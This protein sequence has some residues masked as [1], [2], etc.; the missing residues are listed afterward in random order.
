MPGKRQG[1]QRHDSESPAHKVRF[2]PTQTSDDRPPGN[3]L[4]AR[5]MYLGSSEYRIH[6]TNNPATIGKQVSSGRSQRPVPPGDI[7][8]SLKLAINII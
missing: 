2:I 5:A 1:C 8:T 4:G 6:G 7:F 3:P